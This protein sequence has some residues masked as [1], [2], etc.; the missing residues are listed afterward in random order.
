MERDVSE[1][2]DYVIRSHS[3]VVEARTEKHD[4]GKV[5][6]DRRVPQGD[7]GA[8]AFTN[9]PDAF[10]VNSRLD[11]QP[12]NGCLDVEQHILIIA[13]CQLARVYFDRA[14][15]GLLSRTLAVTAQI[16]RQ[17]RNAVALQQRGEIIPDGMV[18]K[19]RMEHENH[20]R[21]GLVG[22][23]VR[24]RNPDA[25]RSIEM[26]RSRCL[27]KGRRNDKRKQESYECFA[28]HEI[29]CNRTSVQFNGFQKFL[30]QDLAA[31]TTTFL[32]AEARG[33]PKAERAAEGYAHG[34]T[35]EPI[36]TDVYLA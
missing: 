5:F 4:G 12:I 35:A 20:R 25:V 17:C 22:W 30:A 27:C 34:F 24:S 33:I 36:A 21:V 16:D 15:R 32:C 9:Q 26:Y 19:Y 31:A 2:S 6:I 7:V 29:N 14:V 23:I 1:L 10:G 13:A 3:A 8:Y 28:E 11:L 18:P